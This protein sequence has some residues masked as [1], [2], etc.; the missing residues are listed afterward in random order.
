MLGNV[1][2]DYMDDINVALGVASGKTGDSACR[3]LRLL[4]SLGWVLPFWKRTINALSSWALPW[5]LVYKRGN[6]VDHMPGLVRVP[7]LFTI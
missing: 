7:A 6:S 3:F 4:L 2:N 5:L 1:L